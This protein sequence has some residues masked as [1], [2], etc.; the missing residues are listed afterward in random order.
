MND[1]PAKLISIENSVPRIASDEQLIVVRADELRAFVEQ[2]V[3]AALYFDGHDAVPADSR[4][5]ALARASARAR[6]FF[7]VKEFAAVIGRSSHYVS[8]R[9]AAGVIK[10]LRGG[11]PHRIPLSEDT[12]WNK[13][14]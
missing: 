9:C 1:A 13:A 10:T 7:T 5:A 4:E 6:G 11:T 14:A 8:D 12:V 2:A 3:R